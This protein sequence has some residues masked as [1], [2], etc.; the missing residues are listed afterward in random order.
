[1]HDA[2]AVLDAVGVEAA[3]VVGHSIGSFVAQ[4]M[5]VQQPLRVERLVVMGSAVDPRNDVTKGLL[6]EIEAMGGSIPESFVREF[7]TSSSSPSLPESFLAGMMRE[8][9]RL[10]T[11][12]WMQVLEELIASGPVPAIDRIGVPVSVVG[13]DADSVF[14]ADE[15]RCLAHVILHARLCPEPGVGHALH[16]ENERDR[17]HNKRQVIN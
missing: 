5:A 6:Q 13:G 11:H 14:S 15:H 12:L 4:W 3:T 10:P 16:W 8:S 9:S 1:V 17:P 2:F 7:Q